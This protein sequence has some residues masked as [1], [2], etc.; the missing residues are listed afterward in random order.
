MA[1]TKLIGVTVLVDDA[2]RDDLPGMAGTLMAKGFRLQQTLPAVGILTGSVPGAGTAALF[3]VPGVTSVE[4]ERTD[5][6][7][8]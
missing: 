4:P 3:S 2:H 8:Q 1:A 6:R 7:T 5:Y